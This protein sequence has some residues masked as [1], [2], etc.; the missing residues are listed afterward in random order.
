MFFFCKI[1]KSGT[2]RRPKISQT[3]NLRSET[4]VDWLLNLCT[5]S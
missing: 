4:G 3:Q 2:Q 5:M 1:V